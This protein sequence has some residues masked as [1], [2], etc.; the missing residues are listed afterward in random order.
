[1][2]SLTLSVAYLRHKLGGALMNVL[3]FAAG[4]AIVTA[5]LLIDAQLRSEGDAGHRGMKIIGTNGAESFTLVGWFL[6]GMAALGIFVGLYHAIGERRYDLAL[7][8]SLGARP[9]KLFRL[10]L[11]EAVLVA[12]SGALCGLALGHAAV[13]LVGKQLDAHLTGAH[14]VKEE[15]W[16]LAG[17]VT[18]AVIAAILPAS[19]IYRMDIYS[20]LVKR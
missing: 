15:L 20:T 5:L 14:I 16:L 12:L 13:E 8:R 4:V 17:A 3:T 19:K 6:I 2:N 7:M 18:L 1:M 10:M 9:G 11:C